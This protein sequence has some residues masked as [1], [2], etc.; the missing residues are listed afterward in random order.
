MQGV[1][2]PLGIGDGQERLSFLEGE[3]AN[4]PLPDWLW[5]ETILGD[6]GRF[7]RG[8]HDASLGLALPEAI[9]QTEPHEPREV[10]CHNDFA[11]YNLVFRDGVLV[12]A[13]DFDTAS[14][15]P[16][17]RDLAYLAYRLVP[18]VSDAGPDAPP[19]SGRPARLGALIEAYGLPFS[20]GEVLT[21]MSDRLEELARFADARAEKTGRSEFADHAELYRGDAEAIRTML[22]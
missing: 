4:Y 3:V 21:E 20:P 6:C 18:Y 9:W 14:P 7:L 2:E 22:A 13:I 12:G 11:P 10:V 15:G 16:R 19:E 17:I 5:S 1:P 8:L